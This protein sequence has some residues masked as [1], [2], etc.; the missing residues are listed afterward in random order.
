[1]LHGSLAA[2][3]A[4]RTAPGA[5][6]AK[7]EKNKISRSFILDRMEWFPEMLLDERTAKL[8]IYLVLNTASHPHKEQ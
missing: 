2:A 7:P 6:T 8:R 3:L 5:A 4:W 1:M